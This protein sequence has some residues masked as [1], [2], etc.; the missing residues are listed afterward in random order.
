MKHGKTCFSDQKLSYLYHL[1]CEV[2][3]INIQQIPFYMSR[4]M[5]LNYSQGLI[6]Q[7]FHPILCCRAH[8]FCDDIE[9]FIVEEL[10][11]LVK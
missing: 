7:N 10:I 11:V 4:V 9:R 3:M 6:K 8:I 5:L 1:N 2:T